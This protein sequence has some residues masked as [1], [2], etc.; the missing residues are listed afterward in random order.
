[1]DE[2]RRRRT[3]DW[4]CGPCAAVLMAAILAAGCGDG[5]QAGRADAPSAAEDRGPCALLSAAEVATVLPGHDGGSVAANGG[6]LIEG[7]D[8]YQC[9]YTHVEGADVRLFTLI[10]HEAVNDAAFQQV[11][12]GE[13][14]HADDQAVDAGDDAWVYGTA[15]DLKLRM[16]QGRR[17]VELNLMLPDAAS[18]QG[19]LIEL[20]RV[21]AA[22]N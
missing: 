19:A 6:S 21:L 22:R 16:L 4:H 18:R 2:R 20:A 8:S 14:V 9:S 12:P 1:M 11:R 7:V 17:I 10:V 5:E 3:R 15:D 13:S